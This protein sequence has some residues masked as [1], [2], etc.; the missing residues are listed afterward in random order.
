MTAPP[1]LLPAPR[2]SAGRRGAPLGND[3]TAP[4]TPPRTTTE[5]GHT[6]PPVPEHRPQARPV[7][8]AALPQPTAE[9]VRTLNARI[10]VDT[11]VRGGIVFAILL[12]TH[13]GGTGSTTIDTE[14][15]LLGLCAALD[16]ADPSSLMPAVG[17]RIA[18]G[19]TG[20]VRL[21]PGGGSGH[22]LAVDPNY[23]QVLLRLGCAVVAVGLDPLDPAADRR[24]VERYVGE[25]TM[26][27]RM[28]LGLA[29]VQVGAS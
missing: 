10:W 12:I 23:V 14:R 1:P 26:R 9:L 2:D 18:I 24:E 3:T 29:T 15:R 17:D 7:N 8:E 27:G 28:R 21:R 13:P 5:A 6:P 22:V 16:L 11:A 4:N 20:E 19:P 25:T